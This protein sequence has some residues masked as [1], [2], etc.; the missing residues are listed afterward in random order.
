MT[1]SETQSKFLEVVYSPKFDSAA[2]AWAE[3][4]LKRGPVAIKT[5][6][7]IYRKNLVFG[8]CGALQETYRFCHYLLGETNFKFLCREYIH[9]NPSR[10]ADVIEYGANFPDF[11]IVRSEIRDFPFLP[12][13]A[14]LEWAA[15]RAFYLP[16]FESLIQTQYE[17]ARSY[18]AFLEA[19]TEAVEENPFRKGVERILVSAKEGL[20][21]ITWV[22]GGC[23]NE[24]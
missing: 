22:D 5:G 23:N 15:E 3:Q 14:R 11:L 9:E 1:L 10:S 19:G 20:P 12:D 13:I 2:E 24:A 7:K 21:H 16:C 8:L 17:I 6:F 4:H 18:L